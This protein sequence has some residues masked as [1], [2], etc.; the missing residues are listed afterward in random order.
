MNIIIHRAGKVNERGD[1][2]AKCYKVPKAI[3]LSKETWT[4]ID[5]NVTCPKCIKILTTA[6]QESVELK[7]KDS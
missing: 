6:I 7:E 3:N 5:K 2:S 4:L 1:I